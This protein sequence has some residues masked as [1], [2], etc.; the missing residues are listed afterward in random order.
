M[1]ALRTTRR[2][3]MDR[4]VRVLAATIAVTALVASCGRSDTEEGGAAQTAA[5]VGEGLATGTVEVWAMGT[6]GEELDKF[7]KAFVK[8]NPDADIKVTA[9]PWDAA[10]DKIATAIAGGQTPDVTMVGTTW[11]G[12][13]AATGALD[14]TPE[15][16]D[17]ARFFE[18][19]WGTTDVGGTNYGM[20]WYVSLTIHTRSRRMFLAFLQPTSTSNC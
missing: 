13:F 18:G 4:T 6:E 12:E 16:I 5:A 1:S 8:E 3:V 9:I 15:L 10:H 14:P 17:S 11:M 7:A 20:P 19:A 2:T